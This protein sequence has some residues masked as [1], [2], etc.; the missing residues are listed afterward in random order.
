MS[1]LP[2]IRGSDSLTVN[3]LFKQSNRVQN[4]IWDLESLW[5][6][7]TRMDVVILISTLPRV[8]HLPLFEVQTNNPPRIVARGVIFCLP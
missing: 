1:P 3:K 4:S 8:C 5:L 7:N 2:R 6:P